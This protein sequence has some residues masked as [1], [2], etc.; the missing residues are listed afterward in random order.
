[1]KTTKLSKIQIASIVG[2]IVGVVFG[3]AS[4]FV[5]QIQ[6]A[7]NAVYNFAISLGVEAVSAFAGTFKGYAQKTEEEVAKAK[8]KLAA[9]EKAVED[10]EYQKALALRAEYEKA[11]AII[12][13]QEQNK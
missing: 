10:A 9:K 7:G 5:P 12:A 3:V 4:A 2:A 11:N 8:E 1:M 6:I 13:K